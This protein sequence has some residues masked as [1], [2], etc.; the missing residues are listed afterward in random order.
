MFWLLDLVVWSSCSIWLFSLAL[1]SGCFVYSFSLVVRLL[2]RGYSWNADRIIWWSFGDHSAT[3]V[4]QANPHWIRIRIL[5]GRSIAYRVHIECISLAYGPITSLVVSSWPFTR[6]L[7]NRTKERKVNWSPSSGLLVA[8][9]E[10]A[11]GGSIRKKHLEEAFETSIQRNHWEQKFRGN[12]RRLWQHTIPERQRYM[13]DR[14]DMWYGALVANVSS[15]MAHCCA[16]WDGYHWPRSST[17]CPPL[18]S[19]IILHWRVSIG[20]SLPVR[21]VSTS[22]NLVGPIHISRCPVVPISLLRLLETFPYSFRESTLCSNKMTTY[23]RWP[24]IIGYSSL[25]LF[26]SCPISIP[27][28][29]D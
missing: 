16:S 20:Q 13:C 28:L 8:V 25:F 5:L 19:M 24:R 29:D 23:C 9:R 18:L 10:E 27:N 1:R 14:S 6:L 7:I 22:S 17:Q 12:I 15:H 26:Q 2:N 11:F 21:S 3:L 4:G